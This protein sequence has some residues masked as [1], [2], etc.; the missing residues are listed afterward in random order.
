MWKKHLLYVAYALVLIGV[1]PAVAAETVRIAF[2]IQEGW[3]RRDR[4]DEQG[5]DRAG[6][7]HHW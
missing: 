2:F 1:L 7:R 5:R 4:H 6:P 3:Q